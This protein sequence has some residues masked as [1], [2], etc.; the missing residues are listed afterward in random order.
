MSEYLLDLQKL[1]KTFITD[2]KTRPSKVVK[3]KVPPMT[4]DVETDPHKAFVKR[5]IQEKPKKDDIVKQF[6]R[7]ITVAEAD[8]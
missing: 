3:K 4:Q 8:L 7:F 6:K 2:T 5:A 1:G